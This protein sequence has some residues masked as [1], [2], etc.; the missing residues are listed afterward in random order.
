MILGS[1]MRMKKTGRL[2]ILLAALVLVLAFAPPRPAQALCCSCAATVAAVSASEWFGG[3]SATFPRISLFVTEE[4]IGHRS[5]WIN[6]FW[7]DNL[8]PAMML[9]SEQ[10]TAV[11]VQQMQVIGSFLDAKHQ[12]ETQR[13]LQEL[14][15]RA[16]KDYHPSVGM[17]EF[18]TNV[19]SLAASERRGEYNAVLLSQR[20]MDRQ[21]GNANSSAVYGNDMDKASRLEQFKENFCDPRDN[22]NG[23][24][25]MCYGAA[26]PVP[27]PTPAQRARWNRDI[28]YTRTVDFPWTLNVDFTDNV[29]T[30]AEEEIIALS[31]NLYAHHVFARPGAALLAPQPGMAIT[32]MQKR[33]LDMRSIVAKR[34]VAENSFNAITSMKSR[35]SGGSEAFLQALLN[36]LGVADEGAPAGNLD[37]IRALLGDDPSYYAQM[38]VLTKKIYQNPQF[39]TNL[40]DKPANVRRKDVALQAI[41]LMQKFDMFK[42]YLRSEAVLSVL[43]ELAVSDLQTEV[44]NEMAPLTTEGETR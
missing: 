1:A 23:L 17:C 26:A 18:G 19:R 34:N 5:W 37:E 24:S 6:V 13:L 15:A 14:Q 36:Q 20:S 10:L 35:G 41:G 8:L 12:L 32:N 7:E 40:Y 44:E 42:S 28:D 30:D 2:R 31:N 11:A 29:Q 22:N 3:P 21:L 38:E 16:H 33:Y 27:A 39:Y 43:L 9:M 25:F 4:F